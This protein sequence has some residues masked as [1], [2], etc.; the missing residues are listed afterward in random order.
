MDSSTMPSWTD[1]QN[2]AFERALALF[3]KETPDRWVKVAR[4]VGGKTADEVKVHYEL[5]VEDI[6]LIESNQI[7]LPKYKTTGG[8]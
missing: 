7:P 1:K 8:W 5:V 2:K 4:A 3:D 6:K